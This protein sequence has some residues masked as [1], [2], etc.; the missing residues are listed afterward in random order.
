MY[1][2]LT[3]L[4]D[5]LSNGLLCGFEVAL[6]LGDSGLGLF[7]GPYDLGK[8]ID[9]FAILARTRVEC[10]WDFDLEQIGRADGVAVL[11][12]GQ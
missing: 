12:V 9:G 3:G 11:I 8:A 10:W 5:H 4:V 7:L 1:A 6:G 2:L